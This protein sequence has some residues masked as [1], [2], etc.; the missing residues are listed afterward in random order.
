[1]IN[2]PVGSYWDRPSLVWGLASGEGESKTIHSPLGPEI[3]TFRQLGEKELGLL[4]SA[5]PTPSVVSMSPC[6]E[7]LGELLRDHANEI[8]ESI[9]LATGFNYTDTLDVF[10]A[11]LDLI[12]R[13]EA[14]SQSQDSGYLAA[15]R[16]IRVE[17]LPVGLVGAILPQNAFLILGVTCFLHA[18]GAGNRVILRSPTV[19]ARTAGILGRL[20][21][22]AGFPADS[23]SIVVTDSEDFI[24]GFLEASGPRLLHFMGSSQRAASILS[25]CFDAGCSAL[26]D[27]EG[28][29][30]MF[31]DRDRDPV[32]AAKRAWEGAIRYN[33]QTCTSVNGVFVHPEIDIQFR[34]A[35]RFMASETRSNM[36]GSGV[37]PLFTPEQASY[38]EQVVAESNGRMGRTGL[39]NGCL[40][41]PTLVEDPDLDSDLVVKGLFAP[42]MWMR[43]GSFDDFVSAWS[44]NRYPLCAA[45]CSDSI[46]PEEAARRLSGA[47]RIV[48]NGDPSQED[49]MEPW[50]GYPPCGVNPVGSWGEK[51]LRT[52]QIDGPA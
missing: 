30:W 38:Y 27:G 29:A 45:V 22:E 49:P 25:R 32:E 42:A 17:R 10:E 24:S 23:F 47:S 36:D 48:M 44:G 50:G 21:L 13:F 41:P 1:M 40:F 46:A 33:G 39:V 43:T 11:T 18:Y 52:V 8:K 3:Q 9:R 16:Q 15:D 20:L 4:F 34:T 51:Y 37:G 7:R 35:L 14:P 5:R 2:I 12:E 28:N 6:V 31:V 19:C 26:I